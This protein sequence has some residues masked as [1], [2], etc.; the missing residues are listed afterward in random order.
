MAI[1]RKRIDITSADSQ[2]PRQRYSVSYPEFSIALW[3]GSLIRRQAFCAIWILIINSLSSRG[4]LQPITQDPSGDADQIE[5][6]FPHAFIHYE[7]KLR[8]KQFLELCGSVIHGI[9]KELMALAVDQYH[10]IVASAAEIATIAHHRDA[11]PKDSLK[12][13]R[14]QM[15]EMLRRSSE[16]EELALQY[17]QKAAA[18]IQ[19]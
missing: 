6:V 17:I 5:C 4:S 1:Q 10:D 8:T 9:D 3:I 15:I 19:K 2:C 13:K 16:Q 7:N 14:N 18:S 11:L 12:E